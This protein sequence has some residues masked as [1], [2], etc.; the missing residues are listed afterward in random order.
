MHVLFCTA[1]IHPGALDGRL[2]MAMIVSLFIRENASERAA[3]W[4]LKG[5]LKSPGLLL[6]QNLCA[7]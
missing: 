5:R 7:N 4:N 1:V 6:D 3:H 2:L